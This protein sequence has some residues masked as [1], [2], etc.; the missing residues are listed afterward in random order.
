MGRLRETL[1][2][3]H[4]PESRRRQLMAEFARSGCSRP[5]RPAWWAWSPAA[6]LVAVA[7][8]LLF[9]GA[10]QRPGATVPE[11]AEANLAGFLTVDEADGFVPVPYTQPLA[12][13]ELVRI[14]SREVNGAELAH[15]GFD[16]PAAYGGVIDADVVV[17]EDGMPRAVRLAGYE[18]F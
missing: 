3:E 14:V 6:A 12:P 16:V 11:S 15:M 9:A 10:R 7:L 18:G 17:G 8:L 5:D 1:G 2:R 13:G 4:S